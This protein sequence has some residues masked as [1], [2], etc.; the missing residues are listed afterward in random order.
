[1]SVPV[2]TERRV[3]TCVFMRFCAVICDERESRW[4]V[5]SMCD[6]RNRTL[7]FGASL[8]QQPKNSVNRP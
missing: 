8:C 7:L 3:N 4:L 1:M 5:P 2:I 6:L